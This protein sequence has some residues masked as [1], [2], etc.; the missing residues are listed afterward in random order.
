LLQLFIVFTQINSINIFPFRGWHTFVTNIEHK[1]AR[2]SNGNNMAERYKK[3]AATI[4][5]A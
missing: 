2:I 5:I 1:A 4:N 3:M